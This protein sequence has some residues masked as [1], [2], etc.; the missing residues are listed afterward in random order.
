MFHLQFDRYKIE[1]LLKNLFQR[2][3]NL[4]TLPF[5]RKDF[6]KRQQRPGAN[7]Q[8]V[9][10]IDRARFFLSLMEGLL[11]ISTKEAYLEEM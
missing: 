8:S 7:T 11:T 1:S 10:M 9:I 2:R 3:L 5:K 6:R 4:I